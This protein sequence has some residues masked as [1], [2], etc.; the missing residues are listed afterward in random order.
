MWFLAQRAVKGGNS[1]IAWQALH[2]TLRWGHGRRVKVGWRGK[3][4]LWG[5]WACDGGLSELC[6]TRA[7]LLLIHR[8]GV[9]AVS[10]LHTS[11]TSSND[12]S[13][14]SAVD[15]VA[16]WFIARESGVGL[17]RWR[18]KFRFPY[19]TDSAVRIV[20]SNWY[21]TRRKYMIT[22]FSSGVTRR[23]PLSYAPRVCL[24]SETEIWCTAVNRLFKP[25]SQALR[26]VQVIIICTNKRK[27]NVTLK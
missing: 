12:L 13:G 3:A 14:Q 22:A 16:E 6:L 7:F 26:R 27:S 11:L 2:L 21:T 24:V 17:S 8:Q 23:T 19:S 4:R 1:K 25:A 20:R 10:T 15:A 5:L 18:E 9:A